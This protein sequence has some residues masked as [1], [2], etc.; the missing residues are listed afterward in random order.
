M[1]AI[2]S[3]Q[4]Q[5][6]TIQAGE[7]L[8][9]DALG[10]GSAVIANG[11][12]A[13]TAYN[14]GTTA[15]AIGPFTSSRTISVSVSSAISYFIGAAQI[16]IVATRTPPDNS[17]TLSGASADAVRDTTGTGGGS[18]YGL[19]T[20]PCTRVE[21]GYAVDGTNGTTFHQVFW[22]PDWAGPCRFI[23]A[24][25]ASSAYTINKA[26]IRPIVGSSDFL[27]S[28]SSYTSLGSLAF[29]GSASSAVPARPASGGKRMGLVRSD[30]LERAPADRTDGGPGFLVAVR[31]FVAAGAGTITI[32]GAS[33]QDIT[34][35]AS[36]PDKK[37]FVAR[38]QDGGDYVTTNAGF[39]SPTNVSFGP[40]IG[41]E[42][43]GRGRM[44]TIGFAGDSIASGAGATYYGEGYGRLA[45]ND[46]GTEFGVPVNFASLAWGGATQAEF[47]DNLLA[48]LNLGIKPDLIVIPGGSPNGT[49]TWDTSAMQVARSQLGRMKAACVDAGVQYALSTITPANYSAKQYGTTDATGRLV[50]NAEL[51]A[52]GQCADISAALSGVAESHGQVEYASG[53][54]DLADGLHPND[55][56]ALAAKTPVISVARKFMRRKLLA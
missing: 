27:A 44:Y 50:L 18:S 55:A 29:A 5:N 33:T 7:V 46:L 1:P 39:T 41:V 14:I 51:L 13:G 42:F 56:G 31:T 22:L 28:A 23:F 15:V 2:A 32:P 40:C 36:R 52:H 25:G 6:I 45:C 8:N 16:D 3:G 11:Q 10:A 43:I 17:P 24:N 30:W 38:A 54:T 4:S 48:W 47:R 21:Y 37:F 12:E 20:M 49:V 34:N 26:A 53:L 19:V 9:F 35:W